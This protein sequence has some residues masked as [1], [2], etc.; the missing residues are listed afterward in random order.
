MKHIN[1]F[2]I[3]LSILPLNTFCSTSLSGNFA[4]DMQRYYGT[5]YDAE[6]YIDTNKNISMESYTSTNYVP[7]PGSQGS[8]QTYPFPNSNQQKILIFQPSDGSMTNGYYDVNS[9]TAH[10][11]LH[12]YDHIIVIDGTLLAPILNKNGQYI[13]QKGIAYTQI[14]SMNIPSQDASDMNI[15]YLFGIEKNIKSTTN[16]S[17][18]QPMQSYASMGE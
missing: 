17:N 10:T 11:P 15:Y 1:F 12:Q 5:P 8:Y 3:I 18:N 4:L 16:Q 2:A 14:G 13:D 7:F 9:Q 6:S